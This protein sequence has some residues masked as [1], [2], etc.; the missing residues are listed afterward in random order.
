MT[1]NP[2]LERVQQAT[3][4]PPGS[5]KSVADL[6]MRE[7]SGLANLTM[8]EVAD[9]TFTSKPSLVRFAKAMGY[10][11]WRDFRLAFVTAMRQREERRNSDQCVDPN[12]PFGPDD[13]L[14]DVVRS[15]S[16]LEQQAIAEAQAQV[17][18][19][20]LS[21]AASRV[22]QARKLVFL[23]DEP[24]CF[25]GELFAYKLDQIGIACSVPPRDEWR[26]TVEDLCE[27]D[28]AIIVSYSG[29]GMQ[30][31]PVRL[32]S[33]LKSA[34]VA[35]VA[36][37]NSGANWLHEQCDCVLGFRPREHYYSKISGYYS[38]QCISFML[39]ALFSAVFLTNY[40]RNEMAKLRTIIAYERLHNQRVV[41]VLPY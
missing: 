26:A 23:G 9:L 3:L 35:V 6:L 8:A 22:L 21:V 11:G 37:T 16:L 29:N 38:E 19:F 20:T 2:L 1:T 13:S 36:I 33:V 28:C 34:N 27:Q 30:R 25:Y 15:V 12:H 10:S 24:N 40:D 5:R 17:D 4:E 14:D 39:D 18:E 41:D 7:G 31:D 32:L